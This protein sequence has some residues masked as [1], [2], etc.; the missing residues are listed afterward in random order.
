MSTTTTSPIVIPAALPTSRFAPVELAELLAEAELLTRVDRK[1]LVTEEAASAL[2][3]ALDAGTRI[4][5][6]S[7]RTSFGYESSYFDTADLLSY[8]QSAHGRRR[9]FKVRTRHY[10]DADAAFVEVKV[11][12]PR[13]TTVKERI[14]HDPAD[15]TWLS[16]E[17]HAFI[18]ATLSSGGLD[19]HLTDGLRPT[20]VTRYTRTTLLPTELDVRVT[21]DTDLT[22]HDGAR[23]LFLPG[24]VIVETKAG[25]RASGVDRLLWRSGHR[26]TSF[27]KYATG[28]AILHDGLPANKWS[29]VIRHLPATTQEMPCA[30]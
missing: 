1:Y 7:D 11:R 8:R 17:E 23:E 6:I 4:L 19:A 14:E 24:L 15:G 18:H 21:L 20:L 5:T 16:A 10:L 29:R 2:L 9:R 27:S 12:G 28:M 22:W 26:P 25:R 13:D 30:A 3:N